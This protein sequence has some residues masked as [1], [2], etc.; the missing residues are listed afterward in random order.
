MRKMKA[1]DSIILTAARLFNKQGYSNTGINQII[2][3]AGIAKSTLYLHF[4][5]KED[6]LITYLEEAGAITLTALK[7]A[8]LTGIAPEEKISAIFRYLE[9]MTL[10]PDFYGCQFLNIVYEMPDGDERARIQIKKQKDAVRRLFS[11]ILEPLDMPELADEIYTLF[12]GAL[13]A[14][15]VHSDAWPIASA[16]N[17]IKKMFDF[18][19][20]SK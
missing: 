15:K 7:Q 4:R 12:E 16:Q 8:A 3:E 5:S 18:F 1:R 6:L 9:Q 10:M 19:L 14:Q 13:T 11:G 2:D 20:L 17:V